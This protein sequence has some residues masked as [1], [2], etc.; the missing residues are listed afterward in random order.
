MSK[1][2]NKTANQSTATLADIDVN[3]KLAIISAALIACAV[4]KAVFAI[5][6]DLSAVTNFTGVMNADRAVE[7][8]MGRL[9][10][11]TSLVMLMAG[12]LG[13]G[14]RTREREATR[15]ARLVAVISIVCTLAT[16]AIGIV[17]GHNIADIACSLVGACLSGVL[18]YRLMS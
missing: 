7:S 14:A 11:A 15:N 1:K 4:A 9:C 18:M 5:L 10:L 13:M 16:F 17:D 2:P 6:F 8:G 12:V 3:R